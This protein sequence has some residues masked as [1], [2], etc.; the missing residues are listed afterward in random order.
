MVIIKWQ[1]MNDCRRKA[2]R[3]EGKKRWSSFWLSHQ[4]WLSLGKVSSS[5]SD[6]SSAKWLDQTQYVFQTFSR[7]NILWFLWNVCYQKREYYRILLLG[8]YLVQSDVVTLSVFRAISRLTRDQPSVNRRGVFLPISL[9]CQS[10]MERRAIKRK[11]FLQ[12]VR[13]L[14]SNVHTKYLPLQHCWHVLG[15]KEWFRG[16]ASESQRNLALSHIGMW[17]W[18]SHLTFLKQMCKVIVNFKEF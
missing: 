9:G 14:P 2:R 8:K 17:H 10:G 18:A 1:I 11:S 6:S 7:V 5:I 15:D 4:S 12:F 13:R 3:E 16:G